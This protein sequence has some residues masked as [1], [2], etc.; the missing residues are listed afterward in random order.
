M[1]CYIYETINQISKKKITNLIFK[2]L[3]GREGGTC[4]QTPYSV[5]ALLTFAMLNP[6]FF[7]PSCPNP[8]A[9]IAP[10]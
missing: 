3:L 10:A 5:E 2:I 8:G 4:P 6:E 9:K 7:A 1:N